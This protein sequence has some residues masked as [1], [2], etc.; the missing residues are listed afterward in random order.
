MTYT[1][2][3]SHLENPTYELRVAH[4][5]GDL[6]NTYGDNGNILM[7]RYVGSKLN[8]EMIFDIVSLDDHFKADDYQLAF[9]GGG[10]DY[11]QSI[12]AEHL[13]ELTDKLR[14]FI[15]AGKPMLAICGGYQ[16]LGKSYTLADGRPIKCTGILG[17]VTENPGNDRIIGDV[18]IYNEDFDETY[19]GFENHG[20]RTYLA[21]DEN[22]LG[23]VIYGGGNN[24]QS[25]E[26]GFIYKN[27]F[28]SYFHGPL[29]SRNAR[30]AYRLVT[31][32]LKQK[33]GEAI[34]LPA[35]EDILVLEEAGQTISDAKRKA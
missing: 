16:M 28:G 27:T 33:Y 18:K 22:P 25:G 32:A 7:L 21:A 26:E 14:I 34:E 4:L 17:H 3:Q 31:I 30:I 6:M 2:I 13:S 24:G 12:I 23:K 15:E 8:C 35:F 1:S 29:L 19:Y 5:Y 20:G 10:Q 9:W 11:E